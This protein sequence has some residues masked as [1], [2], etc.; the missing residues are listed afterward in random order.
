MK[1]V[2]IVVLTLF[3]AGTVFAADPNDPKE[4]QEI[5]KKRCTICH[6]QDRIETAIKEGQDMNYILSKMMAMGAT[7]TEQEKKVLGT[8][9]GSPTKE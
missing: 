8:F 9:W 5:I 1:S 4:Y 3:A 7:L 6:T 2:V